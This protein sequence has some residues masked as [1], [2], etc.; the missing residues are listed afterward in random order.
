MFNPFKTEFIRNPTILIYLNNPIGRTRIIAIPILQI[1]LTYYNNKW[2]HRPTI[3]INTLDYND[4][5]SITRLYSFSF[6]TPIV[7]HHNKS[8]CNLAYKKACLIEIPDIGFHNIILNNY[9]LEK[10]K[11][12]PNNLWT[13]ALNPLIIV[14][15]ILMYT[16]L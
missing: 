10:S 3:R 2:R 14:Q 16:E 15:T 8:G 12:N 7:R 4:P 9:I 6:S 13:F 1:I 11:S 5:F